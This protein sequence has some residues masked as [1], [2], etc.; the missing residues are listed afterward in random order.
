MVCQWSLSFAG[1]LFLVGPVRSLMTPRFNHPS[2]DLYQPIQ[3]SVSSVVVRMID[4]VEWDDENNN[5]LMPW[6]ID[7]D[8]QLLEGIRKGMSVEDLCLLLKRGYQGVRLRIKAINNPKHR[9]YMRLYGGKDWS[10]GEEMR[11]TLRPCRDVI[12][13]ILW[14]PLLDINDFSFVYTDRWVWAASCIH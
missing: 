5:T 4:N 6:T 1:Y 11:G 8:K 13:R 9:A 10:I 14:D 12:Q 3:S 7:E 2:L